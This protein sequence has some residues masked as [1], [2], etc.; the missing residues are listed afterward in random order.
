MLQNEKYVDDL[1]KIDPLLQ[2][3]KQNIEA[4]GMPSIS[5]ADGYGRLLTM[6]VKM[7]GASKL[8]EVGA[9]GG[10]SGICLARGLSGSGSLVSLELLEQYAEVAKQHMELAGLG[11][12]VEYMLGDARDSFA[13]LEEQGRTFDFF[14]IDAD[15]E[16]YPV[17]LDYAIKLA[18]PGAIIVGDNI[19]LRGRTLDEAKQGPSVQAVR[20][21]N[22]TIAN[23]PRLESTILPGYDGLAIAIVRK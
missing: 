15:K 19:F 20:A 22:E 8:L 12:H 21:F 3:V 16:G 7:S 23:D 6:L 9:L 13:K 5:V 18:E 1:Y 11:E 17:Y 14:F 4:K 2:I 10:Y